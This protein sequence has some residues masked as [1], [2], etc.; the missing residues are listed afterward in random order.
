MASIKGTFGDD[1]NLNGGSENDLIQAYG[2]DDTIHGGD[3]DDELRGHSGSDHIYG[4]AG[5]DRLYAEALEVDKETDENEL[6]GGDG[7]DTLY[8]G[9]GK[10]TYRGG[11]GIDTLS[12]DIH[13]NDT[14]TITINIG[15]E[16]EGGITNGGDFVSDDVENVDCSDST[17]VNYIVIGS[18]WNNNIIGSQ[19]SDQIKG[20]D[21]ND[22]LSA[23]TGYDKLYGGNGDDTLVSGKHADT[24]D[25][26]DGTD[27]ANYGAL[28]TNVVVNLK[29]GTGGT[30]D[31]L[32]SIENVVGSRYNDILVGSAVVNILNGG[33]GNDTLN[34]GDD[35]AA[36][37]LNAS[38]GNDSLQAVGTG[39]DTLDGGKDIDTV[40]FT[41]D[42]NRVS[43]ILADQGDGTATI[44][45]S[46]GSST[47]MTLR[48]IEN[49]N[50]TAGA[51]EIQGNGSANV[52]VGG[53]GND[54]LHGATGGN[55]TLNGGDGTDTAVFTSTSYHVE[56][57]LAKGTAKVVSGTTTVSTDT[58]QSIENVT[59]TALGDIIKGNAGANSLVG[60]DGGDDLV[61]G[62]GNDGLDGGNGND[63]LH[64]G[65]GG[66][67]LLA[68]GGDDEMWGGG[69]EDR[70][71]G[72]DGADLLDGDGGN[73][74]VDYTYSDAAIT[75]SLA[76][77]QQSGTGSGGIA[78]GD[79]LIQIEHLIGSAHNDTLNGN[80]DDNNL[81]GNGGS[82]VLDG[83]RGADLLN[84]GTGADL[85]TGGLGSDVFKFS[86]ASDSGLPVQDVITDFNRNQND[87]IDLSAIDANGW[88]SD[89]N[90]AF[91]FIG[92]AAFSGS[93]GE[94]RFTAG[95]KLLTTVEGDINGD[96]NADFQIALVAVSTLA[97]EDF[98]L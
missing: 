80:A 3:G 20:L 94:L 67:T 37:F 13:E 21:G 24:L 5:N 65:N 50:G 73:D 86:S 64:G 78:E 75:I 91:T 47:T 43:V 87:K 45:G 40:S 14:G 42:G 32:V 38:E 68:G 59:G 70:L 96:G 35:G 58:L 51:D 9:F 88:Q 26:G 23:N 29:S 44:I 77:G 4:D 72:S 55:D 1:N 62:A 25:G 19:F 11:D 69:G 34:G 6:N 71:F 56:V 39:A 66:D 27:T 63:Q 81:Q 15:G 2:G 53:G 98:V 85:L 49:V 46:N 90:G 84:G 76:N 93:A 48:A 36:D 16:I 8:G 57:R 31:T 17:N 7:N 12:V 52:L 74:V 60:G 97:A 54:T 95:G 22:T 92:Q 30:S 28:I 89:G 83:G 18:F 10:D 41:T 79:T 82:D 61:G 33:A